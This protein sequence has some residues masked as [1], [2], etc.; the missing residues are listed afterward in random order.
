[1]K[2]PI[3]CP[4]CNRALLNEEIISIGIKGWYKK[5]ISVNHQFAYSITDHDEIISMSVVIYM[6]SLVM[7][8][9]NFPIETIMVT[10]NTN[11]NRFYIP[12]FE[13][14]LS[15][16]NKLIDKLKKYIVFS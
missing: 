2:L 9:W 7:V 3:N 8:T 11:A 16:Y 15:N 6:N 10:N 14:D 4:K 1:M 12:F 13:P 5:C